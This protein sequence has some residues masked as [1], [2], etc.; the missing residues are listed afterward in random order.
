MITIIINCYNSSG[1]PI[2]FSRSRL[3]KQAV[4]LNS[5][6]KSS[7]LEKFCRILRQSEFFYDFLGDKL[8]VTPV[9]IFFT[10]ISEVMK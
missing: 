2:K 5:S 8:S 9:T 6:L 1:N 10:K 7:D 3:M 4:P